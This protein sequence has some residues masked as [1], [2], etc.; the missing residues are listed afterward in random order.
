M[1]PILNNCC[2]ITKLDNDAKAFAHCEHSTK[3]C[4]SV[5]ETFF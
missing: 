5:P 1:M 3:V 4:D 2:A